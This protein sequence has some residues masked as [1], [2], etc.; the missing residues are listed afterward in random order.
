MSFCCNRSS[1]IYTHF[2]IITYMYNSPTSYP[3]PPPSLL[4]TLPNT[5]HHRRHNRRRHLRPRCLPCR[6]R[7]LRCRR[8]CPMSRS[9]P[10]GRQH[11]LCPARRS[12]PWAALCWRRGA[13][14]RWLGPRGPRGCGRGPSTPSGRWSGSA[15]CWRRALAG[16]R[17]RPCRRGRVW[18]RSFGSGGLTPTPALSA[19]A[20]GAGGSRWTRRCC[21]RLCLCCSLHRLL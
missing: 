21:H 9:P 15:G 17:A 2:I 14:G 12:Q 6:R 16:S 4:C 3:L 13:R 1:S 10:R 20:A 11:R 18:P 19:E 7:R 8:R 5:R